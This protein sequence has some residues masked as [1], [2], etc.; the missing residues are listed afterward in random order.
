MDGKKLSRLFIFFLDPRRMDVNSFEK[1][2]ELEK[3]MD[4]A[5]KCGCNRYKQSMDEVVKA[6]A[7]HRDA[8]LAL[9]D[10][11]NQQ[12]KKISWYRDQLIEM[13]SQIDKLVLE[14]DTEKEMVDKLLNEKVSLKGKM[15]YSNEAV[16]RMVILKEGLEEEVKRLKTNQDSSEKANLE[17]ENVNLKKKLEI[18]VNIINKRVKG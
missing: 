11:S 13:Q 18:C 4:K 16:E 2:E 7:K 9:K 12:K 10:I 14:H 5:E 3:A 17:L 8:A 15:N 1:Y 6:A